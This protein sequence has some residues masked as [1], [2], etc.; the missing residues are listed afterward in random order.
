MITK[1]KNSQHHTKIIPKSSQNQFKR[2]NNHPRIIKIMQN[3][4]SIIPESSQNHPKNNKKVTK[5]LEHHKKLSNIIKINLKM[6]TL[7]P[8]SS[9][10]H[11]KIIK[12]QHII[13]IIEKPS[14]NHPHFFP[15]FMSIYIY[16][17][18]NLY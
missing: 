15:N 6:L 3:H 17:C 11:A 4:P 1:S 18:V 9:T 16:I 10:I 12:T 2:I 13:S 8:E 5:T 14:Q 7:I